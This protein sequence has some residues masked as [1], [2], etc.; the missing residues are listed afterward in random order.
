MWVVGEIRKVYKNIHMRTQAVIES[1]GLTRQIIC[2]SLKGQGRTRGAELP[3]SYM[4]LAGG[5]K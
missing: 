1:E 3:G 2:T 5:Y 4:A